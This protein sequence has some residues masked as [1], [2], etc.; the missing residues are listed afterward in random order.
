[1]E[2]LVGISGEDPKGCRARRRSRRVRPPR[3]NM[4]L[5]MIFRDAFYHAD[6]HP[7]T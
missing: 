3:A 5:A 7:G 1:M 2:M 6:P 4:Y